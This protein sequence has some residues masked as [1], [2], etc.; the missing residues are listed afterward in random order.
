MLQEYH[1][2]PHS[3]LALF[4]GVAALMLAGDRHCFQVLEKS[5]VQAFGTSR[6][7]ESQS[8]HYLIEALHLLTY[9]TLIRQSDSTKVRVTLH[10]DEVVSA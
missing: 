8:L 4:A 7:L 10:W 5:I 2:V 1:S 3:V 9:F 6:Q